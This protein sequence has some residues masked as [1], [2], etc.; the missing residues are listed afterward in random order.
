MSKNDSK[1]KELLAKV[2]DQ[3]TNLGV[4]PRADWRTNGIFK[5][6]S[7]NFFNLNTV[8]NFQP[9]LD[10]LSFLLEKQMLQKQA[11]EKL[12]VSVANFEWDGYSVQDWEEDFKRRVEIIKWQERKSQLEQTRKKM[13]ALVSE[14]ARTEMELED[15]ERLLS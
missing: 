7:G 6:D 4:K 9:L 2:E 12:G 8:K 14:E 1:I 11:A 10:G 3:Q 5:Y 13:R 15:I